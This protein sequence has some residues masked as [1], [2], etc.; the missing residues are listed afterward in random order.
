MRP[1]DALTRAVAL[2]RK[3]LPSS[4]I[5]PAEATLER[6]GER[7]T[8]SPD[9]TVVAL[10]GA[11]GSGKSSLF[12]ALVGEDLARVAVTRPTTRVPLAVTYGGGAADLLDWLQIPDRRERPADGTGLILAD[13]PDID[14]TEA[15]HR[16][17]AGRMA[18]SV[19]VLVWV[20]DPQKYADDVVHSDYLAPLQRSASVTLVVLNQVDRLAASEIRPVVAHL[21]ELLKADGLDRAE[22][23]TTSAVTGEGIP[24]LRDRLREL[25][26]EARAREARALAEIGRAAD[27]LAVASGFD[28]PRVGVV[29]AEDSDRLV[30][31]AAA[32]AGMRAVTDAV[33]GSYLREA[34]A[35]VGWV[36]V[37]W[38][39]RFRPDP[40]KRLH[41]G[42]EVDAALVR[43]SLPAA[44]PVQDAAV[45]SAA[46]VMV[47]GATRS[48]PDSWRVG[49]VQD[50][51]SRVPGL[52]SSLD[53]AIAGVDL[54]SGRVPL[55]WRFV[56][57]LQWILA[58]AMLVGLLWLGAIY[59][60]EWFMLPEPPTPKLGEIPW[61]TV[62]ALGGAL[63]GILLAIIA[64]TVAR[65]GAARR[66]A[67]V[68][69]RIHAAAE[70]TV[71]E[72]F[73]APLREEL[74]DAEEFA[75][76][77]AAA[78]A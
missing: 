77:L 31:A 41:L 66:A 52:V 56:G 14:S 38:V 70:E 40:L 12:N 42:R 59:A 67:R 25:A 65:R 45:R 16:E 37:R 35:R 27:E 19:D 9:R 21:R 62:L 2:G 64:M 23:L 34:R 17:I 78:R 22:I 3:R 32:A 8:R 28:S 49:A 6:V 73:V 39:R 50:L 60:A 29:S 11:T 33:R 4:V 48:L 68:R 5:A 18:D 15:T 71:T 10:L 75:E 44:T 24:A 47:G 7:S 57:V 76:A 55:W 1:A 20:L 61:P 53:R 43:T 36:P 69:R 54:E 58:A 13:L 63:A 74:R 26:R 30:E 46:Q 72:Q 51:D